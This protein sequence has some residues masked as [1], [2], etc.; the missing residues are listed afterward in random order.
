MLSSVLNSDRAIQVNIQI[1]RS[2]VRLRQM[3][4]SHDDL[5]LKLESLEQRYDEQFKIVFDA[6]RQL[7]AEDEEPKTE[8][9]FKAG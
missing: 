9:G 5:R 6:M 8:I 3:V 1:M 4:T 7:L 2:F